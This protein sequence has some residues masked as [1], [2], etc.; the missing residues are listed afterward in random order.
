MK[1]IIALVVA[2][3]LLVSSSIT[4]CAATY[5][6]KPEGSQSVTAEDIAKLQDKIDKLNKKIDKLTKAVNAGSS[7]NGSS[8]G[9]KSDA[10][11]AALQRNNAVA[12]GDNIVAQGGHVELNGGKSNVTFVLH[13]VSGGTLTS[14]NSLANSVN[15]VLIN[16]VE[17][18]SPGVSFS[19]AKANFYV[20]G[21]V[22]GDTI[23]AYQLQGKKW[24]QVTVAEVRK[25]HVVVNLTRHGALAFVRVQA[26]AVAN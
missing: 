15:G 6:E 25:D 21:V 18:S 16:C 5:V 23:A 20:R 3:A 14:A 13:A 1:K 9:G 7:S 26:V 10:G 17:T 12:W 24:V 22:D 8:N 2:S 11:N 19:N 4:V